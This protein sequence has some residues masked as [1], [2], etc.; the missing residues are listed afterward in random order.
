MQDIDLLP[1]TIKHLLFSHL[2]IQQIIIVV[3]EM[4]ISNEATDDLLQM[5]E[6]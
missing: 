6:F 1:T 2:F 5:V 4:L 3:V